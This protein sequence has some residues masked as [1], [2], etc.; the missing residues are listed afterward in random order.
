MSLYECIA[1]ERGIKTKNKRKKM[2]IDGKNQ[3]VLSHYISGTFSFHLLHGV[4]PE[5][6]F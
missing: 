4:V 3:T 5:P 6:F 2:V 1:Y